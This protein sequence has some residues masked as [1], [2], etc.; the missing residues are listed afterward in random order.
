L[1]TGDY[2]NLVRPLRDEAWREEGNCRAEKRGQAQ[3]HYWCGQKAHN[4]EPGGVTKKQR[5]MALALC[6]MCPVQWECV[7]FAILMGDPFCAW[8]VELEDRILLSKTADW[9]ERVF[10]AKAAGHS[11]RA[12]VVQVRE[13]HAA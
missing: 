5:E 13:A 11:V 3:Q 1:R 8:A 2:L 10:A 6:E 4:R 9:Q 12:V 7:T